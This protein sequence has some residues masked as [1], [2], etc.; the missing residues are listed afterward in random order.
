MSLIIFLRDDIYNQISKYALE[1]DKLQIKK[2]VWDDTEVLLRIIEKR[3]VKVN[4]IDIWKT[5]YDEKID[6]IPI[7]EYI[8]HQIIPRPRDIIYLIKTASGNA[9]SRKHT[10][11]ERSDLLDAQMEYS[12]FAFDTLITESGGQIDRLEILIYE[13]SGRSEIV[14][15]EDIV[16]IVNEYNNERSYDEIIRKLCN[17]SF[18]G[19]EIDNN[20]FIFIYNEEDFIRYNVMAKRIAKQRDDRMRRYKIHKAF[21][22]YLGIKN[23]TK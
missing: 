12:R 20:H 11:I 9:I 6:D 15:Y 7:K 5:Y 14:T 10:K 8:V 1:K 4:N 18:L 23:I 3:M 21:H 13:F 22:A 2:I 17:L 16:E 19:M